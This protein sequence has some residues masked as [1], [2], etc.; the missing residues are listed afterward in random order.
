[1]FYLTN[2]FQTGPRCSATA[3]VGCTGHFC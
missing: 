2:T 1:M 3:R